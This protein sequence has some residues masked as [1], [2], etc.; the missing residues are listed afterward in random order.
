MVCGPSLPD[1]A[2]RTS[3]A[4]SIGRGSSG[5][6]NGVS[7]S[8]AAITADSS[9]RLV[10][11]RT[12]R[13]DVVG[14]P[15]PH[16]PHDPRHVVRGIGRQHQPAGRPVTPPRSVWRSVRRC[17]RRGEPP[18]RRPGP[19]SGSSSRGRRAAARAGRRRA[20]ARVAH[21]PAANR[22]WSGRRPRRGT[23]CSP[24]TLSSR[25]R[26][27]WERSRSCASSTSSSKARNASARAARGS[28][29]ARPARGRRDR[30]SR[31]RPRRRE[32]ARRR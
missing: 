10:R 25:A 20:R 24:A 17:A 2:G 14:G 3:R 23:R 27:S 28:P 31:R 4:S 5:A 7:S 8:T 22:R 15:G 21:P 29:G 30:Q 9:S 12:A 19:G 6:R 26:W 18:A 1:R 11:A 32:R 13:V 16:R